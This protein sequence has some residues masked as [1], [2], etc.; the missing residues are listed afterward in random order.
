MYLILPFFVFSY[1]LYMCDKVVAPNVSLTSAVPQPKEVTK[2]EASKS[3][4]RQS[5]KPHSSGKHQK[6]VSYPD[7]SLEEQEK[8]DLKASKESS[9]CHRISELESCIYY[10][11]QLSHFTECKQLVQS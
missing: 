8:M 7:V 11:L 4:P 10:G 3:I 1:Y 2:T 5:E 9:N 6:I